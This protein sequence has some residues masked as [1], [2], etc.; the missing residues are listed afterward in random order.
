MFVV[1]LIPKNIVKGQRH[2]Q[3]Q[4]Q[5]LNNGN[6]KN[7]VLKQTQSTPSKKY[8]KICRKIQ[9][10]LEEEIDKQKHFSQ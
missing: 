8:H 10:E 5:P 1:T 7:I 6:K 4:R 2:Q 9:V 3:K